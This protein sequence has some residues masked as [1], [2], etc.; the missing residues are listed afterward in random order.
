MEVQTCEILGFWHTF[1]NEK[2]SLNKTHVPKNLDSLLS[3]WKLRCKSSTRMLVPE[4]CRWRFSTGSTQSHHEYRIRRMGS[5]GMGARLGTQIAQ[6]V[7]VPE[8]MLNC[9][10]A[11]C[12]VVR[13]P[14]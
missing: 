5:T 6:S 11:G 1:S 8:W 2:A 12:H 10:S 14:E 7:L 3:A 4:S 9:A 13:V